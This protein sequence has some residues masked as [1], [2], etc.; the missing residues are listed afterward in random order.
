[1]A[2]RVCWK[3]THAREVE[4]LA[5]RCQRATAHDM[6]IRSAV[7]TVV[8]VCGK[9]EVLSHGGMGRGGAN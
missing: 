1:M 6:R 3:M 5:A 2:R 8:Q 9:V 7:V 4:S